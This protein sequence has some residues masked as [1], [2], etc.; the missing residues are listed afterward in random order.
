MTLPRTHCAVLQFLEYFL[1]LLPD[2][3]AQHSLLMIPDVP[4]ECPAGERFL[5]GVHCSSLVV[6]GIIRTAT[7]SIHIYPNMKGERDDSWDYFRF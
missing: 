5:K 2:L 3:A 7:K 1:Y 4:R 6:G